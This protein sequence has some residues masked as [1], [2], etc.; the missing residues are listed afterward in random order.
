[1]PCNIKTGQRYPYL[2]LLFSVD[3]YNSQD[4][5]AVDPSHP[6]QTRISFDE[7]AMSIRVRATDIGTSSC[8]SPSLSRN[9]FTLFVGL[10]SSSPPTRNNLSVQIET[11]IQI[12]EKENATRILTNPPSI[13]ATS[14]SGQNGKHPMRNSSPA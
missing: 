1:M 4:E 13:A 14:A 5:S 6:P 7:L 9:E 2:F 11:N 3:R 12:Y 10:T 8:W